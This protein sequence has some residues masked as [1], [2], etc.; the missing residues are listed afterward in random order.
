MLEEQPLPPPPHPAGTHSHRSSAQAQSLGL[1]SREADCAHEVLRMGLS[2]LQTLK[3]GRRKV[4]G[5]GLGA[6]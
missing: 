6:P 2:S 4:E 3:E 1:E 5:W